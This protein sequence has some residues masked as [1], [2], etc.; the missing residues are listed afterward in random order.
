MK[1]IIIAL[2][3]L[4]LSL[5]SFSCGGGAGSADTP[6]GENPGIPSVVQ[7]LPSVF[8]AQTNSVVTLHAKVLDGNG[9]AIKNMP[10]TFTDISP[11]GVLSA[12]TA[13][14]NSNGLATVTL[15]ST[16]EG[17]ATIQAEVNKGAG[18]VRD[19]KTVFFATNVNLQPFMILDADADL[20]GKFDGDPNDFLLFNPKNNQ[21]LIRATVFNKFGQRAAGSFVTFGSDDSKEVSFPTGN[22]ALTNQDGQATI[23]VQVNPSVISNSVR[24]INITAVADNG[25]FGMVSLFIE[26]ITVFKVSVAANP[27]VI[28]PNATSSILAT[29]QL[30]SGTP[31]PDGSTVSFTASCGASSGIITPFAQTTNS[32]ATA[33]FTA[34]S[35]PAS[36]I[37]TASIGGKSG[38]TNVFVTTGLTVVPSKQTINGVAGGTATYTIFGGVP[39]YTV[40][41]DNPAI[42][43]SLP[44]PSSN[45]AFTFTVTVPANT[46]PGTVNLTITDAV[47]ATATATLTIGAGNALS[48]QPSTQTIISPSTGTVDVAFTILGGLP[49]YNVFS[50]TASLQPDPAVVTSS[51]SQ[52]KAH[53]AAGTPAEK[54][55][56]TVLDSAGTVATATLNITAAPLKV[57]PSAQTINGAP[58][59]TASFEILGGAPPY[60]VFSSN[61]SF[62]PDSTTVPVASSGGS[63][64]VTIAPNTPAQTTPIT[65][66]IV[67]S[68]G[69]QATA[70]LGI[71]FDSTDFY[72]IP[73][74]ATLTVGD[75]LGFTIVGGTASQA[76]PFN[77]FVDNTIVDITYDATF[78]PRSFQVTA[79]AAG[80][81][82]ITVQDNNGR[83]T[84]VTVTVNAAGP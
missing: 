7:L 58:G 39:I 61:V 51:G 75:N 41:S 42:Q 6:R 21:A 55:T 57:L 48:V 12:R 52:F 80:T 17:F 28:A 34:P 59:G 49:P 56:F 36:C 32:V 73:A 33:T 14:T 2:I 83:L 44:A 9:K 64:T 63:F 54:V 30:S 81:V 3:L 84:L 43:P 26:P 18:Q 31:A 77:L 5:G 66:T 62:P 4:A 72:V 74:K 45:G 76:I 40:I 67:D 46:P 29:V 50:D 20:D 78:D 69:T 68:I 65:Y 35:T 19:S 37:I 15:K 8:V 22:T 24:V 47:R 38:T 79:N 25:A 10:V 53:I 16:I 13:K 23:L 60:N 70:T 71:S 11:I 1:K 82:N 27:S